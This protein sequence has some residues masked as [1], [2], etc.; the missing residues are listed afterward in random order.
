MSRSRHWF[1]DWT[2]IQDPATAAEFAVFCTEEGCGE[3]FIVKDS[4][5]EAE[6]WTF[7][8][9]RDTGH[10]HFWQTFGHA[11]IVGT[12]PGAVLAGRLA[13]QERAGR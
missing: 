7:N 3:R 12:P 1:D 5:A 11:I 4:Q 2:T 10:L 8:H 9:T 13:R 6:A